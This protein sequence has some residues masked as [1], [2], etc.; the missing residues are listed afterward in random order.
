VD[1]R[2]APEHKFP[3]APDDALT[4]TRSDQKGSVWLRNSISQLHAP[5]GCASAAM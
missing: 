3:A 4:A 5:G 2:L 1:Y